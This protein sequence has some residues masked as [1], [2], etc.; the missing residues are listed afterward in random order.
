MY[1]KSATTNKTEKGCNQPKLKERGEWR[2]N[3]VNEDDCKA[4]GERKGTA[5]GV[6]SQ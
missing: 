2:R 6:W 4:H 3:G 5:R 1:V